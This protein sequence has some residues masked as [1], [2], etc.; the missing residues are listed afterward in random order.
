MSW[1]AD[2]GLLAPVGRISDCFPGVAI[3]PVQVPNIPAGFIENIPKFQQETLRSP[4]HSLTP[5]TLY[6]LPLPKIF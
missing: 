1:N 5:L 3:L 6:F 2:F 4:D